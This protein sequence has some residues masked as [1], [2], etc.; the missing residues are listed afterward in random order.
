M[1]QIAYYDRLECSI[2]ISSIY[3][4]Y[5]NTDKLRKFEKKDYLRNNISL[6]YNSFKD[7]LNNLNIQLPLLVQVCYSRFFAI[8]VSTTISLYNTQKRFK[9]V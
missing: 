9:K 8:K 5:Y 1:I 4:T 2:A 3:S 6:S 7:Q